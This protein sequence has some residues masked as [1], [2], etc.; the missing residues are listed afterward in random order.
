MGAPQVLLKQLARELRSLGASEL[1]SV[2]TGPRHLYTIQ[3]V[4]QG[5]PFPS[6][7]ENI[8]PNL[9]AATRGALCCLS[10]CVVVGG[11][12]L[13]VSTHNRVAVAPHPEPHPPGTSPAHPNPRWAEPITQRISS[14]QSG[15]LQRLAEETGCFKADNGRLQGEETKG[16][17]IKME[18]K[19]SFNI[20]MDRMKIK[21]TRT[22]S[23]RL[24]LPA[25]CVRQVPVISGS[26][27][28]FTPSCYSRGLCE[29]GPCDLWK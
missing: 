12:I 13:N 29:A 24:L 28:S 26:E 19:E 2:T 6:F 22:I 15:C 4:N 8:F 9:Q 17:L 20:G 3:R 1:G 5:S 21:D 27:Q 23:R 16:N 10:V 11:G 25:G 7:L 18:R 14:I